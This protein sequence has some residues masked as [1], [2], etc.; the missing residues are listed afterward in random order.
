MKINETT[1]FLFEN[2]ENV[3]MCMDLKRGVVL[4]AA[5]PLSDR[6]VRTISV[7]TPLSDGAGCTAIACSVHLAKLDV[8]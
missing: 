1:V 2:F 6:D 8:A 7:L 3:T 4:M 5:F